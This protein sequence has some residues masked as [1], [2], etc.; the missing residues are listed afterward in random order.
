MICM[1]TDGVLEIKN[2]SKEEYGISRLEK[3]IKNNY[4]NNQEV[5]IE[6]LKDELEEFSNKDK[7]DDDILIVMLKNN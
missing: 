5:I 2:K 7:Y 1:Y 6:N 4:T 3:F